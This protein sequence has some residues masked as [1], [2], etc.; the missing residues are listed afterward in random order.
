MPT[1]HPPDLL[2]QAG[3]LATAV[4][5]VLVALVVAA[6]I[7]DATADKLTSLKSTSWKVVDI[8]QSV[9][10]TISFGDNGKVTGSLGCNRFTADYKT[11]GQTLEIRKIATTRKMCPTIEMSIENE[12]LR[13]MPTID[14]WSGDSLKVELTAPVNQTRISLERADPT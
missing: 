10:A 9:N 8:P 1:D 13:T 12:L 11:S 4:S 6:C 5:A 3:R 14:R 2:C 7:P